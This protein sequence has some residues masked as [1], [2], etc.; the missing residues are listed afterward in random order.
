MNFG[1]LFFS[2]SLRK[3]KELALSL[4]SIYAVYLAVS[5]PTTGDDCD[6]LLSLCFYN[7]LEW[8]FREKRDGMRVAFVRERRRRRHHPKKPKNLFVST[9]ITIETLK[10]TIVFVFF[11]RFVIRHKKRHKSADF[12]EWDTH[13]M[14]RYI[15]RPFLTISSSDDDV[16]KIAFWFLRRVWLF[17]ENT[18]SMT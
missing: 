15:H 5:F 8:G 17:V 1:S 13:A 14:F 16:L 11:F 2:L 6:A 3:Q 4:H 10:I 7:A 18:K 12:A 9:L